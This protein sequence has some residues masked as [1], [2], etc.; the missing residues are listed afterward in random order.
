VLNKQQ[1][2]KK[3]KQSQFIIFAK[4]WFKRAGFAAGRVEISIEITETIK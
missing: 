1:F 4:S 3:K 2:K